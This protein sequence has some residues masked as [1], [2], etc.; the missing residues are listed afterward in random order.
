M[1]L[2][3]AENPS[4]WTGPT[5]NNT[6]L[7]PG[8]LPTLIDAGVGRP[9][10]LESIERELRGQALAQVLL[11][12]TH[13]DH[14]SGVPSLVVRW[15][16]VR[17]RAMSGSEAAI[18]DGEIITAGGGVLEAVA[19]PGHAP[20]HCC[21]FEKA[22]GDLFCGDLVRAGGTIVIAASR[23]GDLR[24]YLDS[25]ERV[26]ALGP[27]RLLPGHG[28]VIDDPAAAIARYL[29]HRA[30][31]DEQVIDALRDG[32]RT[33]EEIAARIYRL[34]DP[35]IKAAAIDTVLAHLIKLEGEGRVA[36]AEDGGL[37]R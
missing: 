7:L 3:R 9:A 36:R 34:L 25:L 28:P 4:A 2:L 18:A 27:R 24:A 14:A 17:V 33:P 8:E 5:G 22:T 26:L 15:P 32:C 19:T 13:P 37:A 11:T 6:Y 20:D 1:I 35:A 31:R 29:D 10:H 23:G 16:D 30:R 21:F 12:H